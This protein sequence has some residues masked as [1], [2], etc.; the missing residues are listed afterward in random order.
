MP[1]FQF[2]PP[3]P[4]SVQNRQ[5]RCKQMFQLKSD[6][7]LNTSGGGAPWKV[8]LSALAEG[9]SELPA[10][11]LHFSSSRPATSS[12]LVRW[13]ATASPQPWI[14]ELYVHR[15]VCQHQERII[16]TPLAY[17]ING[18]GPRGR[19]QPRHGQTEHILQ[20]S[21]GPCILPLNI[22]YTP[23]RHTIVWLTHFIQW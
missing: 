17:C 21:A 6:R 1:W 11:Q 10:S 14:T 8:C 5:N 7:L 4:S 16:Q 23:C 15:L 3:L 13:Q 2:D 22:P 19:T 9:G 20:P 18:Q 12:A